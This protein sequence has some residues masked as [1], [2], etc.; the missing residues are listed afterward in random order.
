MRR[1]A[2]EQD[3]RD[4]MALTSLLSP[5]MS[6]GDVIATRS[7]MPFLYMMSRHRAPLLDTGM[8]YS[9]G[10]A[11]MFR[12]SSRAAFAEVRTWSPSPRLSKAVPNPL[13]GTSCASTRISRGIGRANIE[14]DLSPLSV[15]RN[16]SKRENRKTRKRRGSSNQGTDSWHGQG[17][18]RLL[19]GLTMGMVQKGTSILLS[20]NRGW[21]GGGAGSWARSCTEQLLQDGSTKAGCS[22]RFFGYPSVAGS[23]P[24]FP[25]SSVGL[26]FCGGLFVP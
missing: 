12:A 9:T 1:G 6:I 14:A 26:P 20:R 17:T 8:S 19:P 3:C 25:S 13:A 11:A 23:G 18:H 2:R 7:S 15:S 21:R 4:S 16:Y 24:C 22:R 10:L 5:P